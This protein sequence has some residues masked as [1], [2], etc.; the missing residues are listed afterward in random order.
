MRSM[1]QENMILN[2][3]GHITIMS[4][5]LPVPRPAAACPVEDWLA[6]L[7]HRWNALILWHLQMGPMRHGALQERLTGI[8]AKVLAERLSGLQQRALIT[9]L[10]LAVFPR[11]MMYELTAQG[12][13]LIGILDQLEIWAKTN[14]GS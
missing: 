6:F 10:P 11:G 14:R 8:T 3:H 7:G 5:D 13:Q 12:R 2:E 9:Q 4:R 1:T